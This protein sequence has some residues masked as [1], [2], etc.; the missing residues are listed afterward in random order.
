ML[1]DRPYRT[2]GPG[3]DR[4]RKIREHSLRL[5]SLEPRMLLSRDEFLAAFRDLHFHAS[6][7]TAMPATV[8]SPSMSARAPSRLTGGAVKATAASVVITPSTGLVINAKTQQF[9]AQTLDSL[10]KLLAGSSL[11]YT[12]SATKVP[13]GA[14]SPIFK[15]S[16]SSAT[17]TFSAA[18]VYDLT[19]RATGPNGV[20]VTG[21]V[22]VTVD[23]VFTSARITSPQGMTVQSKSQ[24]FVAQGLDQFG[25]VMAS[26]MNSAWSI[27]TAPS[28]AVAPTFSENGTTN[29]NT[30]VTFG[31][32]GA[33]GLSV[34]LIDDHGVSRAATASVTVVVNRTVVAISPASGV[35]VNGTC[36]QFSAKVCDQFG[37][38]IADSTLKYTWSA[39]MLPSGAKAPTI[40]ANGTNQAA[41]MTVTFSKAGVYAFK[42]VAVAAKKTT[43]TGTVTVTVGQ[44]LTSVSLDVA[45]VQ[46]TKDASRQF[47]AAGRDQFQNV[48]TTQPT[49]IWSA[50]AGSITNGG[51]FTAPSSGGAVTVTATSGTRSGSATVTV[52]STTFLGLQDAGLAALV[53][54][55][56]ADGSVSRLD[57]IQILRSTGSDD[58]VVDAIELADLKKIL[59]S[60]VTLC[61]PGYVQVLASDV[62]QRQRCQHVVPRPIAWQPRGRQHFC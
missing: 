39:T 1:S 58:G 14:V 51:L 6:S 26:P 13:A 8:E 43:L 42:V 48:M 12:W 31:K 23:Q 17:V 21:T 29:P 46:L 36:Q 57:M 59:N 16:G 22:K 50:T 3:R 30:T 62:G 4:G 11:K 49:F 5:E 54:S 2:R 18:G 15:A 41:N 19:V 52:V 9:N 10:G 35:V 53:Q 27:T 25:K 55:L 28:G 45:Q 60:S 56:D 32:G 24:Q 47:T 61:M 40:S 7:V 37:N 34:R 38:T 20:W 33:Y 44:V